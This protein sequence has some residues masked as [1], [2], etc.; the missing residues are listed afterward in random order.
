ML[1]FADDASIDWD[2]VAANGGPPF[3]VGPN[4]AQMFGYSINPC[5]ED[6]DRT[7][8]STRCAVRLI[9]RSANATQACRTS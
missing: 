2:A 1:H 6:D 7:T 9:G 8:L 5:I 3:T 4:I